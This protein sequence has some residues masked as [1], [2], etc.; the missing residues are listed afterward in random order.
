MPR[1]GED[2]SHE[3]QYLGGFGFGLARQREICAGALRLRL[4]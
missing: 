3:I 2:F 4:P 1:I